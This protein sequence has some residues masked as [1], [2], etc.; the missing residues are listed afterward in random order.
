[1]SGIT[2]LIS[3]FTCDIIS[4]VIVFHDIRAMDAMTIWTVHIHTCVFIL[5]C[6]FLIVKVKRAFAQ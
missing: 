2:Y 1:M 3:S 6:F 4:S 5:F